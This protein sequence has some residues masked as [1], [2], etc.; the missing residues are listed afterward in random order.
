MPAMPGSAE[1]QHDSS[2]ARHRLLVSCGQ[3]IV[4]RQLLK[5]WGKAA[6]R[7]SSKPT[8]SPEAEGAA[9]CLF[10][11]VGRVWLPGRVQ[12]NGWLRIFSSSSDS[13]LN[14]A[15]VINTFAP[16]ICFR[17]P[18]GPREK[19]HLWA[20]SEQPALLALQSLG[21]AWLRVPR[22][23]GCQPQALPCHRCCP[24]GKPGSSCLFR[25]PQVG[26]A[27]AAQHR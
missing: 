26:D 25:C 1:R 23:L 2:E 8:E 15:P 27:A 24:H 13:S 18:G 16:A 22:A 6:E 21:A 5:W 4:P 19:H 11:K 14:S 20:G 9:R 17:E 10:V 3:L 12:P 7:A